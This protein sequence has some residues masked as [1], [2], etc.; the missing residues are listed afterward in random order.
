MTPS[1]KKPD[2]AGQRLATALSKI[3]LAMRHQ[4][5]QAADS[6]GLSP[7]QVQVLTILRKEN[8]GLRLS[9]IANLLGVTA[10]TTS[11][12][13]AA[14]VDKG[15]LSK[16]ADPT[17][18]RALMIALTAEG[19][20]RSREASQWPDFML[21][22]LGELTEDE[23]AAF[24]RIMTKMIR[25]MQLN[26]QIPV[27]KMCATCTYFQPHVHTDARYPH[28]CAFVDAAFGDLELR[29]DCDDQIVADDRLQQVN[30]KTF[31]RER[32]KT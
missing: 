32:K 19:K 27:A 28:H 29:L 21:E 1:A 9:D 10:A 14:M 17:D 15:L 4:A 6:A 3:G 16:E 20:K 2:L 23:Q 13:V 22:G 24:L 8:R 12:A 7:T 31:T 30:W 26:G 25:T 5:W 18:R 11:D